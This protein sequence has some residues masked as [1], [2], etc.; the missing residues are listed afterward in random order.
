MPSPLWPRVAAILLV[1]APRSPDAILAEHR[2]V[3]D[4]GFDS[5]ALAR[6]VVAIETEFGADLPAGRLHELRSATAGALADLLEEAL[7]A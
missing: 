7:A 6:T 1:H 3:E 4:L 5:L 2:L